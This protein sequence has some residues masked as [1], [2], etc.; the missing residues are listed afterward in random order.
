QTGAQRL[1]PAVRQDYANDPLVLLAVDGPTNMAK[2]DGDAATWL[3]P[4]KAFRCEYVARQVAI[5]HKYGLWVTPAE[6]SAMA[7]ILSRCPNQKVPT[8]AGET[9]RVIVKVAATPPAAPHHH[10][11]H[12]PKHHG[13]LDPRFAT[14]AAAIA[15]GYGPYVRGKDPEYL[16]YRDADGDGV[17][18][19]S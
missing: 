3:P 8:V 15:A 12:A 1:S 6:R 13:G 2:G 5:K 11:S 18:C 7:G 9:Q 19:E 4:N 14:C 16:W 17:D 10:A